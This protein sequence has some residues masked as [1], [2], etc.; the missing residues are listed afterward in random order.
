M[1]LLLMFSRFRYFYFL[2]NE[3]QSDVWPRLLNS[4]VDTDHSGKV[5]WNEW[6]TLWALVHDT[7][8]AE[9]QLKV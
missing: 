1:L 6:R 8:L 9:D 3:R 4:L 2:I 5:E 7:P